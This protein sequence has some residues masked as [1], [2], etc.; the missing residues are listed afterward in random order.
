MVRLCVASQVCMW[1]DVDADVPPT[2]LNDMEMVYGMLNAPKPYRQYL[3]DVLRF[4]HRYDDISR[5]KEYTW[6]MVN[7]VPD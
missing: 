7:Y 6:H 3:I 4:T 1:Y 5:I 2:S